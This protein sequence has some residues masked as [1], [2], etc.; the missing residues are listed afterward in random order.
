MFAVIALSVGVVLAAVALIALGWA[1]GA[2]S[3][4]ARHLMAAD[5]LRHRSE[6]RLYDITQNAVQDMLAAARGQR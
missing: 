2:A 6:A 1:T 3:E 4:R 5:S